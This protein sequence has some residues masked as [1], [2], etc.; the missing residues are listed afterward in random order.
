M[1]ST[2]TAA[3]VAVLALS[4][5]AAC[6]SESGGTA[7]D[8]T[9]ATSDSSSASSEASASDS[10]TAE[11]APGSLTDPTG[12]VKVD[13]KHPDP[14]PDNTV[15]TDLTGLTATYD[16]KQLV[17]TMTY[18]DPIDPSAVD[19]FYSGF[20]IEGG[21]GKVD[22][23]R[24]QDAKKLDL[25]DSQDS[26]GGCGSTA[27][28]DGAVVTMTVPA[29]CFGTPPSVSVGDA[30]ATSSEE[31]DGEWVIDWVGTES[32]DGGPMVEAAPA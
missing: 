9:A 27:T 11:A 5:L 6:G 10:P 23:V 8:P 3:A 32:A 20:T 28:T 25:T 24:L 17:V 7:S 15:D 13:G 21:T 31:F 1:L 22:V 29:S 19:D 12:D 18:A 26:R 2:R 14:R 30:Y 4:G 16:G